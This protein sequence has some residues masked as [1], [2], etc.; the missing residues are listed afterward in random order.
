MQNSLKV[1]LV[2]DNETD[3]VILENLFYEAYSPK[4]A[5]LIW[6]SSYTQALS[7]LLEHQY[8]IV[9]C[10]HS[11]GEKNG[12]DLIT[13]IHSRLHHPPPFIM[14]T[15]CHEK[16]IDCLAMNAGATDY[17]LKQELSPSI[18]E[19]AIRYAKQHK[20]IEEKLLEMAHYDQLTG[21]ANR[22]L[23][24]IRLQEN[25]LQARRARNKLALL[26]VDLDNFKEVNDTLG[27]P[28][29]DTL[30]V[31]AAQRIRSLI[32][33]S[34]TLARL[35]G[36][37]FAIVATQINNSD[38][39]APLAD[40]IVNELSRPFTLQ[41]TEILIGA[42]IGVSLFPCDADNV[43]DLMKMSDMAL[44]EAKRLG[45]SQHYFLDKTLNEEANRKNMIK[46]EFNRSLQNY[47]F[48]LHYQ[49]IIDLP[50]GNLASAEVL[51]RWKN[52]KLG[53][54]SPNEFIPIAEQSGFIYPLGEWILKSACQQ[55]NKWKSV[56]HEPEV[57]FA[58]NLSA[59][60]FNCNRVIQKIRTLI[61]RY[62]LSPESIQIEIT[63]HVLLSKS[64]EV[65]ER[66]EALKELG[67]KLSLDDFGTGY[68]SFSYLSK[69]P[70]DKLKIDKSLVEGIP[71][72]P[73]NCGIVDAILSIADSLDIEIV[74]EGIET[75][76][77]LEFLLSRD[78]Q[79]GQGYFF[80]E[81]LNDEDFLNS[82]LKP[83]NNYILGMSCPMP[84]QPDIQAGRM[85]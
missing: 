51:L 38:D 41:E 17:L 28:A 9:L 69:F 12:I 15:G 56:H 75:Q 66:L 39:I 40:K 3:Y 35:G 45:R 5:T 10:D 61:R 67:V 55:I 77:Q 64:H 43:D 14:L 53:P 47:E 49:P 24:H 70:I 71:D 36:D 62:S 57:S 78:C 79:Y 65:I 68:S 42:S 44:Y 76:E 25:I 33:E 21:L 29:G 4:E 1:L 60:Q 81:P 80:S 6:V 31:K 34:D 30:L 46:L 59:Q 48:S 84:H 85:F 52:A 27:H 23:F 16:S 20:L 58:I 7:A 82:H 18:L 83:Y 26:M 13:E 11:L 72:N 54:V 74:A 22:T 73:K 63:E 19:R 8:H 32:R 37:E 2:E 50:T